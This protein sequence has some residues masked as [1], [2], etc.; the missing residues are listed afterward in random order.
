MAFFSLWTKWFVIMTLVPQNRTIGWRLISR[1][2]PMETLLYDI[3]VGTLTLSGSSFSSE[4]T[5]TSLPFDRKCP[6]TGDIEESVCACVCL[7]ACMWLWEKNSFRPR[8]LKPQQSR[9]SPSFYI[10]NTNH[11]CVMQPLVIHVL[12]CFKTRWLRRCPNFIELNPFLCVCA[13]VCVGGG[14]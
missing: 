11:M 14:S 5:T 9:M 10:D 2:F 12:P 6:L 8:L 13:C 3:A 4:T 1:D 7:R